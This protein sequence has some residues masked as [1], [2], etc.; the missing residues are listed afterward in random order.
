VLFD[1]P[2]DPELL[3]QRI[4]RLD[5][6]GQR[7]T[8]H[9]HVPYL[10]GTESEV[11]ARWYSEGL[12]AFEKNLTGA[13]QLMEIL[14]ADLATLR[15]S[16][17]T[18]ELNLFLKRSKSEHT[19]IAKQLEKGRDRLLRLSAN[20]PAQAKILTNEIRAS[21]SDELFADF[22]LKILEQFGVQI[23]DLGGRSFLLHP[24][25]GL[26][27]ALPSLP[28]EGIT[29]TFDRTKALSREDHGFISGDH[30]MVRGAIDLLLGSE[31]G[32]AAYGVWEN[33]DKEA[34]LLEIVGVVESVAPTTLHVDRFLPATPVRIAVDHALTDL[35]SDEAL[36]AATLA[37]G[38]LF[39]LLDR[40]VVRRK[41]IPTMLENA[42]GLASE[43][44]SR[45]V[46]AASFNMKMQL[47][48]EIERLASLRETNDHVRPEEI[49]A[50][51]RQKEALT[52]AIEEAHF[53]LDAVRL[54]RA[55]AS[56]E[57]SAS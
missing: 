18:I 19:R 35:S 5:R 32:N 13:T 54:I 10:E 49:A 45:I 8:I 12:N 24:S 50:L 25:D 4:G 20:H 1:L 56:T 57:K 22:F 21:D 30:P 3:E 29:V 26:E 44:M 51:Q 6:I 55:Q 39:G 27:E 37:K 28:S 34:I 14:E 31:A 36:A 23:E 40:G 11:L 52:V 38:N 7:S 48:S 2:D 16:F 9:I 42:K 41:F 46:G 47:D 53:R 17:E 33:A 43:K 15:K